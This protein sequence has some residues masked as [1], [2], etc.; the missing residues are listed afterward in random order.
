M[1]SINRLRASGEVEKCCPLHSTMFSINPVSWGSYREPDSLYIP[2]CFLL[3]EAVNRRRRSSRPLYIPLCFL[4]IAY[5]DTQPLNTHIPLHSTMFSINLSPINALTIP[6]KTLHSTMFSI[7]PPLQLNPVEFMSLYIPLCF[8]LIY[9][10]NPYCR[11][12]IAFTFHY[13]FY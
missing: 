2:L 1:F 5:T 12:C 10:H 6:L 8:L 3:I 11:G 9:V 7:N 13:V 4:L